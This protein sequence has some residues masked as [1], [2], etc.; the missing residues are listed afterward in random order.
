MIF[1]IFHIIYPLLPF[2]VVVWRQQARDYKMCSLVVVVQ[3]F[4]HRLYQWTL[5]M[6]SLNEQLPNLFVIKNPLVTLFFV[7]D[8][9]FKQFYCKFKHFKM[10]PITVHFKRLIVY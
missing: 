7:S 5:T 2:M 4:S 3:V 8:R 1:Y 10:G 6:F 9:R